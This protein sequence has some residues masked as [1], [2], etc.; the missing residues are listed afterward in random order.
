M[1]P[2]LKRELLQSLDAVVRQAIE[3]RLFS[4][5]VIAG[6]LNATEEELQDQLP[7]TEIMFVRAP[8]DGSRRDPDGQW[9]KL[10][11]ICSTALTTVAQRFEHSS[12][13]D[14]AP[15]GC[16]V[17]A[18]HTLSQKKTAWRIN[19]Q[20]TPKEVGTILQ[21]SAWPKKQMNRD[22][23]L[24]RAMVKISLGRRQTAT[25]RRILAALD[26]PTMPLDDFRELVLSATRTD[27][28]VLLDEM[29]DA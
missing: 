29:R 16:E 22:P 18:P 10:D 9:S 4:A 26:E 12:Q 13:S 28:R 5:V 27:F 11:Y 25:V 1:Q 20:L 17:M 2:A 21:Q 23:G 7:V 14:H 15:I 24:K 8:H 6:D 3:S 19:K